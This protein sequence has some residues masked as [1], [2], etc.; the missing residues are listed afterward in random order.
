MPRHTQ[1][2]HITRFYSNGNGKR[3]P[4]CQMDSDSLVPPPT[5]FVR[6]PYHPRANPFGLPPHGLKAPGYKS[7]TFQSNGPA[8]RLASAW[9]V[10]ICGVTKYWIRRIPVKREKKYLGIQPFEKLKLCE[11][12]WRWILP[13]RGYGQKYFQF[14]LT[15]WPQRGNRITRWRL[16]RGEKNR[17]WSLDL[18]DSIAVFLSV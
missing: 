15:P 5:Q 12:D 1:M 13:Q 9:A 16:R 2:V 18:W 7:Y 17:F 6:T 11:G 8:L 4:D 10:I 14:G 3:V